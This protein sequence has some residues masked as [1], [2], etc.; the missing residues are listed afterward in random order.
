MEFRFKVDTSAFAKFQANA[1]QNLPVGNLG[2]NYAGTLEASDIYHSAMRD[3]FA[4]A[5]D[6]DGTWIG[7]APATE[8]EHKRVGDEP[9]HILHLT[10]AL[11]RSLQRYSPDHVLEVTDNSVIEGTADEK[12]RYHQDGGPQRLPDRPIYIPPDDTTLDAMKLEMV[13][14]IQASLDFI[15]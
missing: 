1:E 3:R 9:A 13:K 14:G 6:G 12:A 4:S 10:G 11:E 5:S 7:L 15:P 8:K 2:P